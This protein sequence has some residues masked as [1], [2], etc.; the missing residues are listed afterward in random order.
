MLK[1][2]QARY[3]ATFIGSITLIAALTAIGINLF[4][5]PSLTANDERHL[6]NAAAQIGGVIKA[7]L[8]RVQAQQRVITE[9]VPQLESD[10]IDRLLPSMV[11]QYGELKVF[12]GGVWPLPNQRTPGRA[13]HSTFYHRDASGKLIVNTHWNSPESQNYFEQSWYLGGLKA[14]A[15]QCNW[16]TAYRDDASPEPRTNCAMAISK[17]GAAYGVATIDVTLG[18]FNDLV[19]SK[20]AE[21][22]ALLMIVE[23]SGTVLSN[24]PE[25]PGNNVLKNLSDLAGQ[26]PFAAALQGLLKT[27]ASSAHYSGSDGQDYTLFLEPIEGTPWLMAVAQQTQMLTAQSSKVLS[28]LAAIQLPMVALLLLLMYLGLRQVMKRLSVLRANIDTLSAG[29]ADLTRRI[30]IRADDEVGAVGKSVNRFI[31]YLQSMVAEV[32]DVSQVIAQG[33]EQLKQ[34]AKGTNLILVRHANETD[35]AVTAI[36]EMSSTAD[37][38]ARNAAQT[39]SMTRTA[40]DNARQSKVVVD[41][42]SSSVQALI[43]EV[44]AATDKVR[45]MEQDAQRINAVLGVIG[46]IAG[47]TNLL[48]LNAAIEAA[49]AGEQGRGFA[50]VAD[51]V[52]ALAGRTQASTS[53][54]NDMLTRLQ[55]GVSAAVVAMENTK[56]SCQ[57]TVDKTARVNEGLDDMADSVVSINDLST[58][59]ATAA[60]QQSAVS[61]E[62]N[63]NIVAVKHIVEELVAE[64]EQSE[65]STAAL[66]ASND[67][68]IAVVR[69][70]KLK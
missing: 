66:A 8:G 34:Q 50:V 45:A 11:N 32:S 63:R 15:G 46:E 17:N 56:H 22:H 37:D 48:A 27:G 12:G 33:V 47:Q 10:D 54:I 25:I 51:E 60:E 57:A 36:T 1:T 44:D 21:T 53:E 62:I 52:R 69:R 35:Q 64:G 59:I 6:T 55:Q 20:E 7:E 65:R 49:R 58:Q 41:D 40:N 5:T 28:T 70:F 29:E 26:Y 39:A 16:A 68:L 31:T 24:Q 18:F 61:E 3:T 30:V 23:K 4:V 42:A 14:P 67:K 38:V 13:K 2:I 19:A 9:T 43:G